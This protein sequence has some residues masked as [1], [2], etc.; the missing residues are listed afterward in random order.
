MSNITS[1]R[2]AGADCDIITVTADTKV[3]CSYQ[4]PVCGDHLPIVVSDMGR[5]VNGASLEPK[6]IS[7]SATNGTFAS[8]SQTELNV[9]GGDLIEINGS[10]F[11]H[12]LEDKNITIEFSD[13][14]KT[15]CVAIETNPT[16]IVCKT[17]AF[18]MKQYL[19]PETGPAVKDDVVV[20][21]EEK[22]VESEAKEPATTTE[23]ETKA[24]AP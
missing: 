11:P 15:K 16:R 10:N 24:P 19:N 9:L 7:C 5:I 17:S 14:Q 1:V 18:D 12:K 4:N 2:F 21:K 22:A 6:S 8:K 23:S 13:T 20:P 3:E